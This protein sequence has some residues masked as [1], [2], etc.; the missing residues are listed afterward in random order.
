MDVFQQ[1]Q[2]QVV[3]A[4][5][6]V[7]M[8]CWLLPARPAEA[9]F[10]LQAYD[11]QCFG[12]PGAVVTGILTYTIET[13]RRVIRQTVTCDASVN[14]GTSQSLFPTV[15]T[16]DGQVLGVTMTM[17]MRSAMS[18]KAPVEKPCTMQV[19]TPYTTF[20]CEADV[21]ERSGQGSA[22]LSIYQP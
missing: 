2:S 17:T 19:S 20:R 18:G 16:A 21:Q 11:F 13:E 14:G 8:T 3:L 7:V 6:V 9:Q 10:R 12:H 1:R 4:A 5:V 22:L 15:L